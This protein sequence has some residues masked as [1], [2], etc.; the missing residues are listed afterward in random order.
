MSQDDLS[1]FSMEELFRAEAQEQCDKL[2]KGILA[3][4]RTADPAVLLEELMRA[5]HSLKGAARI[6]GLDP[7]VQVAH[8][9]EER[10]VDAQKSN[11][12][13]DPSTV[14]ILL[15]GVDLLRKLAGLSEGAVPQEEVSA[16][17]EA[18][19]RQPIASMPVSAA[20]RVERPA[21][22]AGV[23]PAER[24]DVR[25]DSERLDTLLGLAAQAVVASNAEAE[26]SLSGIRKAVWQIQSLLADAYR[27]P[28][29]ERR[30][31]LLRQAMAATAQCQTAVGDEAERRE[32]SVRRLSRLCHRIHGETLASRL[33]P[34][35]DIASGLKR[36][37]RDLARQLGREVNVEITGEETEVDRELLDRL[38]GPLSHLIRNALD[39]GLEAP[40][41]RATAGKSR[42]GTLRI[43]ARHHAGWLVISVS[44]DGRGLDRDEIGR[45]VTARGLATREHVAQM[46]DAELFEFLLLPGFSLRREVTEISGRGVGLDAV[47]TLAH[48]AGGSFRVTNLELA[49]T[50][51]EITLPV[52]LSLIR[53]MIVEIG[54]EKFAL[55]LT[56][57]ARAVSAA[58]AE[59]QT[60]GGRQH[61]PVDGE[62]V[63]ILSAAQILDLDDGA[64]SGDA[65]HTVVLVG[66]AGKIGLVVDR[67]VGQSELSLQR[68]D[69][70]LG[71]VQDVDST[72]LLD[73]G[74]PVVVLDVNDL[75]VTATN[76]SAGSR[77]RP[78]GKQGDRAE[79][80][81]LRVLVADD[82]LTVRELERKLLAGR[83]Y[84]VETAVDGMDAWNALRSGGYDLL[85]TDIDMPRLDGIELVGNVRGDVRLRDLPII[86]VSYKDRDE[87]RTRGLE[88]G[89]DFYLP[90]SSYQDESLL[91]AVVELIGEPLPV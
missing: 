49:G 37:A 70:R 43:V 52:S 72:A 15:A 6:V 1:S 38:D 90:K 88:A 54:G 16:F 89:A 80:A 87:D 11:L 66:P 47:R 78:L 5:A 77:Y 28:G 39:H 26:R 30:L 7:A 76:F 3:L 24:H 25:F 65:V 59:I 17:V 8:V 20:S 86:I 56:R 29:D 79:A 60:A 23:K 61:L 50:L 35:G 74:E 51:C 82:S 21:A 34:F 63:E 71:R 19:A 84:T 12:S 4:E 53:A 62:L 13:P 27:A 40:E 41:E 85:V 68:L 18:L 57:V 9:I 83:G 36:L 42:A 31:V 67:F 64:A 46:T 58:A 32:T 69:A 81:A 33:R 55:P 45:A 75:V 22:P 2:L 10:F 14:D 48:G 91:R 44:D 73:S